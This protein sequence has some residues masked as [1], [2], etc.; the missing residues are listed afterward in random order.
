MN[1]C[2]NLANVQTTNRLRE[3]AKQNIVK[4]NR[5]NFLFFFMCEIVLETKSFEHLDT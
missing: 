2:L 1:G 5:R 3:A 4:A